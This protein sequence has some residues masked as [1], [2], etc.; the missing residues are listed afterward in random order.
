M[1]EPQI[2]TL[3]YVHICYFGTQPTKP[4]KS[5][6]KNGDLCPSET[7]KNSS[8]TQCPNS[9][10]RHSK[11]HSNLRLK[12]KAKKVITQFIRPSLQYLPAAKT[13]VKTLKA[14]EILRV[15]SQKC[16]SA[17]QSALIRSKA[18][19]EAVGEEFTEATT[20]K[21]ALVLS[22]LPTAIYPEKKKVHNY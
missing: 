13:F 5:M 19:A 15:L 9:C 2:K 21:L 7:I 18:D 16:L 3:V 12:E 11:I 10:K 22:R 17:P 6:K 20:E 8:K 4:I 14:A 1:H